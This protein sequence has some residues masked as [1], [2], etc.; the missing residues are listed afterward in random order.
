[1]KK[2][3]LIVIDGLDGAGKATQ[4]KLLVERL[5]KDG[6]KVMTLD[7][8]RYQDNFFGK[9]IGEC[10]SGQHGDFLHLDPHIASVLYAADRFEAAG[11]IRK[12]LDEGRYVILDRYVSANQIHQ[13]GKIKDVRAR[14]EFLH[15]LD[16]LEYKVFAIPK[17]DKVIF[18]DVTPEVTR[19]MLLQANQQQK[20]SYLSKKTK[21]VVEES[22]EYM[23]ASRVAALF[24]AK[25]EKNWER[26]SCVARGSILARE[27][28]AER[29]YQA[30]RNIK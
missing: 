25:N 24:L 8:P 20:K 19:E 1:M 11:K 4:T 26:I 15:W 28:I 30:V 29:V 16:T 14:K 5:K 23:K 9:L 17:P 21:D 10:L 27:V 7:F 22:V 18:L 3:K 12:W 6:K 2:G 13:G